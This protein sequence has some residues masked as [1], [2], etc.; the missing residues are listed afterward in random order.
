MEELEATLKWFMKD[1]SPGPDGWTI[2]F[3][4]AFFDV[5]GTNLL[6]VIEDSRINGRI[7][8]SITYTFTALIPN[9]DNPSSFDEYHHIYLLTTYIR[10][11]SKS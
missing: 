2:E 6:H 4:L 9:A 5:L 1:K 7:D 10:L 8:P 11:L 3:Y